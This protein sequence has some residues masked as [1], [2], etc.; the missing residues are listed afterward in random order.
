[1]VH[2]F[3]FLKRVTKD[4][5]RDLDPRFKPGI[6][7]KVAGQLQRFVRSFIRSKVCRKSTK[8]PNQTA[9]YDREVMLTGSNTR[10]HFVRMRSLDCV[11]KKNLLQSARG[12]VYKSTW[13]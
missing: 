1:M 9:E 11:P 12:S 13:G 4:K 8:S 5:E 7:Q 2:I 10:D 6:L 3:E